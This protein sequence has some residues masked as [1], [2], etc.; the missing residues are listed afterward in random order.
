MFQIKIRTVGSVQS[1]RNPRFV[2]KKRDKSCSKV[3]SVFA[4]N[5]SGSRVNFL[6]V[7]LLLYSDI[8]SGAR[9]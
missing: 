4:I 1:E 7:H 9:P 3:D 6:D 5:K 8:A 2:L